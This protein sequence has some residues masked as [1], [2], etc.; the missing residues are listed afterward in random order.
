MMSI[1]PL[2]CLP[3]L[4]G[5]QFSVCARGS[6]QG[7]PARQPPVGV[8]IMAWTAACR[9]RW[10]VGASASH[11]T[12]TT[13]PCPNAVSHDWG[14]VGLPLPTG[15]VSG[16]QSIHTGLRLQQC[17]LLLKLSLRESEMCS[18][19]WAYSMPYGNKFTWQLSDWNLQLYF[20]ATS[21]S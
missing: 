1:L 13:R 7:T 15:P 21:S 5:R 3:L 14:I 10:T 8:L 18:W 6:S 19:L 4:T 9:C 17:E 11:C 12:S 20:L 16:S 2:P